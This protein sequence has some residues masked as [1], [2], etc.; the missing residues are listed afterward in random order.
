[1]RKG[2]GVFTFAQNFS[3]SKK[4]RSTNFGSYHSSDGE[5]VDMIFSKKS[6]V[7]KYQGHRKNSEDSFYAYSK[8]FVNILSNTLFA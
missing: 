6:D 3:A 4:S 2:R 7:L 5:N 8:R 1:M